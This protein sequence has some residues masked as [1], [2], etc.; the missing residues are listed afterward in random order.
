MAY[1]LAEEEIDHRSDGDCWWLNRKINLNRHQVFSEICKSREDIRKHREHAR[2]W[3]H[4]SKVNMPRNYHKGGE[5]E[6]QS[7]KLPLGTEQIPWQHIQNL[8]PVRT[9]AKKSAHAH[10]CSLRP[11]GGRRTRMLCLKKALMRQ[12][13]YNWVNEISTFVNDENYTLSWKSTMVVL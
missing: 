10:T 1:K 4:R 12:C 5:R 11:A 3:V 6:K 8:F 7:G 13:K 9:Q 2:W